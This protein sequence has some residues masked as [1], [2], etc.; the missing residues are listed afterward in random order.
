MIKPQIM[1]KNLELGIIL[2][3]EFPGTNHIDSNK[4]TLHCASERAH[5][6]CDH[7]RGLGVA[8]LKQDFWLEVTVKIS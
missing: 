4:W 1:E 7:R 6:G 2:L 5:T 8:V 3:Q